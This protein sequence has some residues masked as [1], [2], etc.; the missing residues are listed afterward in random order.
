MEERA[1]REI[2]AYRFSGGSPREIEDASRKFISRFTC[3]EFLSNERLAMYRST[4]SSRHR[5]TGVTT[6]VGGTML[7]ATT[8]LALQLAVASALGQSEVD[9]FRRTVIDADPPKQPYY[10]MVGDINGDR[11]LEIVIAG[12]IGPLVMYSPPDWKKTVIAEGGYKGGVNGELADINGDGRLDIVMGGVGWFEN[13]GQASA[14]WKMHQIDNQSIHDVVTADLNG[15]GRLDIVAR[16]QSAFGQ[17]GNEIFIYLQHQPGQWKKETIR[18]PHGEGIVL[19]DLDGDDQVDIVIGGLWFRNDSGKWIEHAYAPDWTELD[20]KMQVG[21]INGDGRPDI[22]VTPSELKGEHYKISWFE[23]PS[24]DKSL[25]WKEHVVVP[26]IECV[27]HGLALGDFDQDSRLDIA[28]AEM[29][30]GSDPDEV[31]VLLNR[32]NGTTWDKLLLDT[33]G[34]HDIRAA[35][36]NGDGALDIFGANHADVHPVVIWENRL[37]PETSAATEPGLLN[38]W[39]YIEVD[40][41][42]ATRKFGLAMGDLNGDGKGDIVSGEYVYLNPGSDMTRP[43]TRRE[44]S[45]ADL[46]ALLIVDVNDN[47]FADLIAM[48]TRGLVYWVEAD[49]TQ[50]MS[51]TKRQIGKLGN[52]DHNI[53]A[54]GYAVGQLRPGARP[55]VILNITGNMS[56]FEIPNEPGQTPWPRRVISTDTYKEDVEVADMDGDGH[57]DVIGTRTE[58]SIAWWR[59]PGDGSEHW[60]MFEIGSISGPIADRIEVGDLN[61]DGRL[62]VALTAAN[63]NANGVYFFEQPATGPSAGGWMRHTIA[64]TGSMNSLDMGDVN[65]DGYLDLVAG[66]HRG[67]LIL[68][69]FENDGTGN[70]T[71]RMVDRGKESHL[72]SQLY[73]LDGDG[74]LDIISIAWDR[75][76]TLHVWRNDGPGE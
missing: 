68:T 59:N 29:H 65:G 43:W 27:I 3:H 45:S 1:K 30:Q 71:S 46:D 53:S 54:Q 75:Y 35:D 61:G 57:D 33:D 64:R 73:D 18:C 67:D 13:P 50:C 14:Q 51:W 66:E 12:R 23:S 19:A 37:P 4:L 17:R 11:R 39:T 60:K 62:D 15:D 52:A 10:K 48:D 25:A 74:D 44:I 69:V 47:G 76:Q 36:L 21:D 34:S 72:G 16:D 31:V 28:Y 9:G 7:L 2:L 22:V 8:L 58:S 42:R 24:G 70:F 56:Y 40:S 6:F 41:Q 5:D 38:R 55:Q 32:D 20:T 63:G 26:E 49:D